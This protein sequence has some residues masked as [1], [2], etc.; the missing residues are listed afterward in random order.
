MSGAGTPWLS[1]D[2]SL[3]E[4]AS[5]IGARL[6]KRAVWNGDA[7]TWR[8]MVTDWNR[9][10]SRTAVEETAGGGI[11]QGSA[12]IGLFLLEL[13]RLT[14][15]RTAAHA[16]SGAIAHAVAQ[17]REKD[18]RPFSFHSGLVGIAYAA[19]RAG[20]VLERP[21]LLDV[22]GSLV[23]RLDGREREDRAYDVIGGAAG[24]IPALLHLSRL[25]DPQRTVRI[26]SRLSEHLIRSARFEP[27]GWSWPPGGSV[28][29][30]NLTG[31]AHGASGMAYALLD[32]Y[33]ATGCREYRYAAEQALLYE[34]QF[35]DPDVGNWP[36]FRHKE[37]SRLAQE[38]RMGELVALLRSGARVPAYEPTCMAAWCHGA[39]GIGLARLRAY[40]L[41]GRDVDRAEAQMAIETTRRTLDQVG[42]FSLCHGTAGNCETLLVGSAV[43][44]ER[45]LRDAV[46]GCALR[47]IER[48]E[49]TGNP[50]PSGAM[51]GV[52]DPSLMLGEAG[53][54]HSFLRIHDPATPSVLLPTPA[55]DRPADTGHEAMKQLRARY[56]GSYFGTTLGLLGRF[57]LLHGAPA[58]AAPDAALPEEASDVLAARRII[59][60]HLAAEGNPERRRG[61]EDAFAVESAAT[62]FM[63]GITDFTV[64]LLEDLLCREDASGPPP[65]AVLVLTPNARLLEV[66]HDWVAEAASTEPAAPGNPPSRSAFLVHRDGNRVAIRRLGAFPETVLR[67]FL[68]PASEADAVEYVLATADAAD[69]RMRQ[70]VTRLVAEQ[71]RDACRTGILRMWDAARLA[72][73][74][75]GDN[76]TNSDGEGRLRRAAAAGT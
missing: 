47:G 12:G 20:V 68:E 32:M 39:P 59:R 65:N 69:P 42:G 70:H 27:V 58:P 54:G 31:F 35:F 51:G 46:A 26:A 71:I 37:L 38:R 53:I 43:L 34:R 36:D 11:Y 75:R 30:R 66:S 41:I 48:Y 24:A 2:A 19:A 56:V 61:L 33:A 5:R 55:V 76:A 62:D 16:A 64:S 63:L 23:V 74:A 8:V 21:N 52:P 72:P 67:C 9:P 22:A 44:R 14:G 57:G 3:L 60:S 45:G 4:A 29:V 18:L 17:A 49:A 13:F 6:V 10:R 73:C 25:L 40:E 50:W 15:D 7:C 1:G 28:V